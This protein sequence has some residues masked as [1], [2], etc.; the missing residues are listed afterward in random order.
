VA[1][2]CLEDKQFP[3]LNSFLAGSNGLAPVDGFVAKL[4]SGKRAQRNPEFL[5]IARVEALIAGAGPEEAL[6]RAHAYADAGAARV[7]VTDFDQVI[8][9]ASMA[10]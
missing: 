4:R 9:W 8:Q 10:G 2:V 3:K 5:I 7:I 1:G 6:R